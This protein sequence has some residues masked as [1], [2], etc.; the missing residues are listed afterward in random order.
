MVMTANFMGLSPDLYDND[1]PLIYYP[2][3][4]YQEEV[5]KR[6]EII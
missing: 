4:L 5:F 6:K 2:L 1:T 3:L